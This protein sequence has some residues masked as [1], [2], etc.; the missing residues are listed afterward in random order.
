VKSHRGV[1]NMLR[2]FV[3]SHRGV[4]NLLREF[5]IS[6]RNIKIYSSQLFKLSPFPG[7][8]YCVNE[9]LTDRHA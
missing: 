3:K 7:N 4:Y 9:F 8:W 2:E 6:H 5:V 1:Y